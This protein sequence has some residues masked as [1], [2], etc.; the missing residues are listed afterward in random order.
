MIVVIQCAASK[1]PYAGHL[2]AE[3]GRPVEFVANPQIAP[4]D[5]HRVYAR[6]DDFVGNGKTWRQIL[7]DYNRTPGN[8]P[9]GLCQAYE[10]Y[11][12]SV[13]RRLV[14]KFGL[15][16]VYILSAGWGL[17]RADFLTPWYDITFSPSAEA[18][19]RRRMKDRYCDFQMLPNDVAEDVVFLGGKDYLPLFC[20][21][22]A[23][24][25]HADRLL[26]LHDGTNAKSLHSEA[27]RHDDP[28]QL[29]L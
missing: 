14:D 1:Q 25:Q 12:R 11:E 10:L 13:Y 23:D 27:L 9:L 17:I 2:T 21:L 15:D 28:N 19:K 18:F 7:I 20:K 8:N 29:A 24:L 22:T 4:P 16:K 5:D 3:N 6:T 26:Q